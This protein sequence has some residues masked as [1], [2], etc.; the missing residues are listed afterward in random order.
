MELRSISIIDH[1]NGDYPEPEVTNKVTEAFQHSARALGELGIDH[2]RPIDLTVGMVKDKWYR[3]LATGYGRI[4]LFFDADRS[5][6]E[7]FTIASIAS[8]L[9]HEKVH[10]RRS[11]EFPIEIEDNQSLRERT[12]QEGLATYIQMTSQLSLDTWIGVP[13]VAAVYYEDLFNPY[14]SGV[15]DRAY[16]QFMPEIDTTDQLFIEDFLNEPFETRKGSYV[17]LFPAET[18][19][20]LSAVRKRVTEGSALR[21][22]IVMPHEELLRA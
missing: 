12:V 3:G 22:L 8:T 6:E 11:Q 10:S 19:V 18:L 20:G 5:E 7:Q 14:G 4:G 17:T 9:V 1:S 16:D 15:I 21:D 13:C 2:K